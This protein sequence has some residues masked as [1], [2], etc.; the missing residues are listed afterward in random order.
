[1]A[2]TNSKTGKQVPSKA[3]ATV[4][5]LPEKKA[6]EGVP[7]DSKYSKRFLDIWPWLMEWEG[8]VFENDKGDPGG[9]TKFGIDQRSHPKEDIRNLTEARAQE[10]YWNEYWQK[11][12]CECYE[13]PL[14][15]VFFNAAVN[16]GGGQAG[17][18]LQR[19]KGN[20]TEFLAQHE[21]FYYN[22]VESKPSMGK[23]LKGWL[24]R[25]KDLRAWCYKNGA[26]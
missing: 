6:V 16:T 22:L 7:S 21:Q 25:T 19:S 11:N 14:G 2:I 17:K 10:I 5:P 9:A 26:K 12:S 3:V 23:F 8:T 1:M 4:Q 24:N 18:F 15:E 13:F 20:W